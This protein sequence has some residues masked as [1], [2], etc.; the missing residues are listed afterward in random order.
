MSTLKGEKDNDDNNVDD[1]VLHYR[2][3]S[4]PP[5]LKTASNMKMTK[6]IRW[7]YNHHEDENISVYESVENF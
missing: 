4:R 5:W 6:M 3:T 2:H 1:C 7:W